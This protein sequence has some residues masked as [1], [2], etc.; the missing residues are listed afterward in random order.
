MLLFFNGLKMYELKTYKRQFLSYTVTTHV[1]RLKEFRLKAEGVQKARLTHFG[2][3]RADSR[4]KRGFPV[5]GIFDKT[6][7][8]PVFPNPAFGGTFRLTT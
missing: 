5:N 3:K 4:T 1:V 7:R 8:I 6:S 2:A